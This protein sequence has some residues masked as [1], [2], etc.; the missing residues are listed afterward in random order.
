[1]IEELPD[2]IENDVLDDIEPVGDESQLYE[3]FRVVDVYK[4]QLHI[5]FVTLSVRESPVPAWP[6]RS[7]CPCPIRAQT[8][9]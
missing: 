2:D 5:C 4:R 1:M 8:P 3:H 6:L 9:G 7:S